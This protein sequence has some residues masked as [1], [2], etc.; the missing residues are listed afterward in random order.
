MVVC[1][2]ATIHATYD[3]T[4]FKTFESAKVRVQMGNEK[5][6][7]VLGKGCI[8]V[9]FT[10]GKKVTLINVFYVPNM[11]KGKSSMGKNKAL[12]EQFQH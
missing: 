7:K 11:T 6:S 5:R 4:L 8:D 3:K 10:Y 12:S 2:C 9:F 1:T